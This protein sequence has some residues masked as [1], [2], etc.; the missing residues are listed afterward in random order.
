MDIPSDNNCQKELYC[1]ISK[2]ELKMK[3][4]YSS[5]E[6]LLINVNSNEAFST[7]TQNCLPF[8]WGGELEGTCESVTGSPMAEFSY[9][10]CL[11]VGYPI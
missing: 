10:E 8:L 4:A 7:Y 1:T 5:P 2:G 3:K 11:E 9:Q 6:A